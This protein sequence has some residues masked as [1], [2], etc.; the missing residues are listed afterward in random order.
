VKLAAGSHGFLG[1]GEG[2][3]QA[4][5]SSAVIDN[6]SAKIVISY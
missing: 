5:V 6:D 1:A 3:S 2:A 4:K